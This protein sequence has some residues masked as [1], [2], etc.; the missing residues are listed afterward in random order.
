MLTYI[1]YG[2]AWLISLAVTMIGV[3]FLVNPLPATVD[4]GVPAKP[5][6]DVAYLTIKGLRDL[7]S[8]LTCIVLLLFTDAHSVAWFLVVL[9]LVPFGD[10]LIVLRH[11]GGK[12]T[13]FAMHF[14]VVVVVLVTSGL[15][16][17]I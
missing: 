15:L 4:Y 3:R 7:V 12:K 9:A 11:G 2:L 1:A 5:D 13:A 14:P 6:G 16:F 10:T 17:T 8:G